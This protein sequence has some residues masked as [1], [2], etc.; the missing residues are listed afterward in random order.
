MKIRT[1]H[2][3]L[4][5]DLGYDDYWIEIPKSV[6]EGFL[7]EFSKVAAAA[8]NTDEMDPEGSRATNIKIMEMVTSWNLTYGDGD[9]V[10][11]V[12]SKATTDDEKVGIISEVPIDIIVFVASRIAG[13]VNV[14]EKTKDF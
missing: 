9:E 4:G 2:I 1:D 11:P 6:K 5:K 14:P 3:D 7:H 13:T 8:G 12:L 10:M